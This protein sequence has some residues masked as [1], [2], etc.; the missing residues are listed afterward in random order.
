[1]RATGEGRGGAARCWLAAGVLV[2][3]TTSSPPPLPVPSSDTPSPNA[4]I[5][6]AP[7]APARLL[8]AG[9]A[10]AAAEPGSAASS[11]AAGSAAP[12]AAAPPPRA[13]REDTPVDVDPLPVKEI[14]P[15]LALTARFSWP[16]L[17]ASAP[18]EADGRVVERLG[19]ETARVVRITLSPAGR[20]RLVFDAVTFAVERGVELRSRFDR[21]GHVVVWPDQHGYRVLQP[22]T[23]RAFFN[24]GRADVLALDPATTSS[25]QLGTAF[26]WD[27]TTV[28]LATDV[29]QLTLTQARVPGSGT[30]GALVCRLLLELVCAEPTT[31]DCAVDLVPIRG[32]YAWSDGGK[33]LFEVTSLTRP[34]EFDAATLRVPPLAPSFKGD[35]L[36]V[37]PSGPVVG[38]G[39]LRA[40]RRRDVPALPDDGGAP[41]LSGLEL[42]NR[43]DTVAYA[44]L[45]GVPVARVAPAHSVTLPTLRPGRYS[46]RWTD[47]LGS[48]VTA[49]ESLTVP[50]AST[51]GRALDAG[52]PPAP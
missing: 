18:A 10:A 8:D 51:H 38:S 23:A 14:R 4:S 15:G 42:T 52:L 9:S 3:C 46:L 22:G 36:P 37:S 1:M 32:E 35:L 34:T 33:L 16:E 27:A 25:A 12:D 30:S 19:A 43:T 11:R 7:L 39:D 21:Y 17:A 6:P 50:G 29:G 26:G 20:M 5:L 48:T 2:A 49:A 28:V 13:L 24:E 41:P 44:L 40:L 31:P 47:F 45:D